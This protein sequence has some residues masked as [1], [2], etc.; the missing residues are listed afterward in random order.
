M[1]ILEKIDTWLSENRQED[2]KKAEELIQYYIKKH[3][4]N[5]KK[6]RR[7]ILDNIVNTQY[8][9]HSNNFVELMWSKFNKYFPS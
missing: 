4:K 5:A 6:I 2:D 8:G 1:D 7:D 9:R 3:G